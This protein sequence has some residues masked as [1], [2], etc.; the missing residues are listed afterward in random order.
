M[1]AARIWCPLPGQLELRNGHGAD[2]GH[3]A[4]REVDLAEQK[5][6]DDAVGEHAVPAIWMMMLSKLTG[7]KKFVA[8]KPKKTTMKMRP[9]TIGRTAEVARPDVVHRPPRE[10]GEA[11]RLLLDGGAGLPDDLGPG[12]AHAA[13]PGRLR[14]PGDLRRRA[15]GDRCTTSCCVVFA[16]S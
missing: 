3:V 13:G 1:P 6:E 9:M 7:V 12:R 8:L 4:D 15:G 11:A 14:D 16:R 10:A 5:D 2:P